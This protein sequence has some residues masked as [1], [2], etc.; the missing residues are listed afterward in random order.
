[1][2]ANNGVTSAHIG[3]CSAHVRQIFGRG[4]AK[5]GRYWPSFAETGTKRNFG[6]KRAAKLGA[7][8]KVGFPVR[9]L[10]RQPIWGV[11]HKAWTSAIRQACAPPN[12]C[13]SPIPGRKH[14]ASLKS[15]FARPNPGPRGHTTPLPAGLRADLVRIL[16]VNAWRAPRALNPSRRASNLRTRLAAGGPRAARSRRDARDRGVK[17]VAVDCQRLGTG[18]LHV[19]NRGCR[20]HARPAA[21]QQRG[22]RG[23]NCQWR[24]RFAGRRTPRAT[25]TWCWA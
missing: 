13:H 18:K 7:R 19:R 6:Q 8:R 22:Q 15:E 23:Q 12:R 2:L 4:P 9:L 11:K 21:P 25:K 20:R 10:A 5:F 16:V 17:R 1:M 3:L 14:Q 24:H